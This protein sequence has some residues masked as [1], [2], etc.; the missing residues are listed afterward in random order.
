[1]AG[2]DPPTLLDDRPR[3]R[4]RGARRAPRRRCWSL[5]PR[6][7]PRSCWPVPMPNP[8]DGGWSPPRAGRSA[9]RRR[10]G[11]RRRPSSAPQRAARPHRGATGDRRSGV[12]AG[13]RVDHRPLLQRA[14]E[15]R[16]A[17]AAPDALYVALAEALGADT[18][19]ARPAPCP[20]RASQCTIDVPASGSTSARSRLAAYAGR[21]ASFRGQP[22]TVR[23][24]HR[25]AAG[26]VC[27][28]RSSSPA[29]SSQGSMP[30]SR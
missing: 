15:L 16:N 28:V 27:R 19:D 4:H 20:S 17:L 2:V 14:W 30:R 1:M 13:T 21:G 25:F 7:S 11:A 24:G 12:L 29:L 26:A 6:A 23:E 10:R 18:R 8:C 9:P 22:A 5:T 3:G